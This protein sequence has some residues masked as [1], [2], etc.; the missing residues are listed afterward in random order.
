[1]S[2]NELPFVMGNKVDLVNLEVNT[3]RKQTK[4]AMKTETMCPEL[5]LCDSALPIKLEHIKK[6]STNNKN[7]YNL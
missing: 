7:G 3:Y 4:H 5:S 1:M 2:Q 6:E